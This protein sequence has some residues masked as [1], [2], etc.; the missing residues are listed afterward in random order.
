VHLHVYEPDRSEVG[1]YLD[2]RDWLRLDAA[3]RELYAATK[4]RLVQQTWRDL[5]DIAHAK[6]EVIRDVLCRPWVWRAGTEA[7]GRDC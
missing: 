4:C 1:D 3:D 6:S 2:L 7:A 5:N